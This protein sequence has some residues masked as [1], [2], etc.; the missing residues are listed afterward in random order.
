MKNISITVAVIAKSAPAIAPIGP[1]T[2][3]TATAN[4]VRPINPVAM[5]READAIAPRLHTLEF[6]QSRIAVRSAQS[7]T[8]PLL[9]HK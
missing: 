4:V 7:F 9:D 3:T 8:Q 6:T 5:L 1:I 2:A